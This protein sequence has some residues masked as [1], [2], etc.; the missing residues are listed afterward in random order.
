MGVDMV[1]TC[2]KADRHHADPSSNLGTSTGEHVCAPM[3]TLP[4]W[5]GQPPDGLVNGINAGSTLRR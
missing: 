5:P 1:S 4:A 2:G 3:P